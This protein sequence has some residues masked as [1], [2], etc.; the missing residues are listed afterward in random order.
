MKLSVKQYAQILDES[1]ERARGDEA[2]RD[3]IKEFVMLLNADAKIS[4]L[5]D[6]LTHFKSLWNK[7]HS[8]I[9]VIVEAADKEGAKFPN[10]FGGKKV[11]LTVKENKALI[12]GS[13]FKI[14]DYLIDSSVR[15]KIN[16]LR[17]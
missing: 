15:T 9:D 5:P 4:K 12:G 1:V 10:T 8:V 13:I 16:A 7:R 2:K 17:Q 14:G 6:I 3:V 11:S